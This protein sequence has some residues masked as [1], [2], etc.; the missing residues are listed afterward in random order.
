[1]SKGLI[2]CNK[3]GWCAFSMLYAPLTSGYIFLYFILPHLE[4]CWMNP[5]GIRS[6]MQQ[7]ENCAFCTTE[8]EER[9]AGGVVC[10][11]M[12]G[13][14]LCDVSFL[15]VANTCRSYWI[16]FI[17][18][19]CTTQNSCIRFLSLSHAVGSTQGWV[20]PQ[21][22]MAFWDAG[23]NCPQLYMNVKYFP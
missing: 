21:N 23:G 20:Y 19:L 7:Q 17:I 15:R 1:M 22:H 16:L 13:K 8:S 9:Q 14:R 18:K 6:A 11:G 4:D 12:K 10:Q 3:I 5:G 2:Y